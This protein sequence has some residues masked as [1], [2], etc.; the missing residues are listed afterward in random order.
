MPPPIE[1]SGQVTRGF[2]GTWLDIADEIMRTTFK[3]SAPDSGAY[4]GE[5]VYFFENQPSHAERWARRDK[6]PGSKIAVISAEVRYGRLLNLTDQPHC[7]LL[8]W[9]KR[10]YER[11]AATTLSL[12]TAIDIAAE[13]LNVEVVKANRVPA[14]PSPRCSSGLMELGF[15]A[16]V[17]MILAVRNLSNILSKSL[18]WTGLVQ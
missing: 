13:K 3:M 4:L 8:S 12:A 1:N 11:K 14:N 9:F 15:S 18:L 17:E 2:H 5:G 6:P 7:D 10:E 16:D